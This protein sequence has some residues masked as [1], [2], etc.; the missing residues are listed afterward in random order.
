MLELLLGERWYAPAYTM[1]AIRYGRVS[2]GEDWKPTMFKVP[3]LPSSPFSTHAGFCLVE[4][5]ARC[6]F[7]DS[8]T[9]ILI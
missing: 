4:T 8:K 9:E 1:E 6:Y 7:Q 2:L 3:K 5:D